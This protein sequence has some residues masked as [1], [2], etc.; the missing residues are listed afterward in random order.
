[1][2]RGRL[3]PPPGMSMKRKLLAAL[4]MLLVFPVIAVAQEYPDRPIKFIQGFP[5]GGDTDVMARVLGGEMSKHLGQPVIVEPR[6]GASGGLAAETVSQ[7]SPDG[8]TLLVMPSAHAALGAISKNLKYRTV[9]DF[10]WISV[11]AV[12]PFLI[13]VR[14]DSRFKTLQQLL[15]AARANPGKLNF[16]SA[17]IG[18]V[19]H[20]TVEL[21]ASSTKTKFQHVPYRGEAPAINAL[22]GGEVDFAAVTTGPINSRIQ[23]GEFRAL[24]VTSK[25]RWPALP[26]IPTVQESGVPGFEVMGWTGLAG[27]RQLPASI[28]DRL[29]AEVRHALSVPDVGKKLRALGGEPHATSPDEMRELVQRQLTT[30]TKVG[31]E[32]GI[33]L[34]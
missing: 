13:C 19:L 11:F 5:A 18:T 27:P 3:I 12:S 15:A 24:A 29:N 23:S 8:Y 4:A 26:E 1:M 22:L 2:D 6:P 14:N 21:L 16:G 32:A 9:D 17:G 7:S 31:H 10:S 34:D 28:V 33:S 25:E 30:W 20:M